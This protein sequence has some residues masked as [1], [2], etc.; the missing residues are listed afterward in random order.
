MS[1]NFTVQSPLLRRYEISSLNLREI[2]TF[3]DRSEY[4]QNRC[5][6]TNFDT[7]QFDKTQTKPTL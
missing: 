6:G 7:D 5:V 1:E 2:D 3:F 4:R